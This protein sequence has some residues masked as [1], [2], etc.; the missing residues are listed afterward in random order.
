MTIIEQKA[1]PTIK[2]IRLSETHLRL[3]MQ[4]CARRRLSFSDFARMSLLGN[5][6]RDTKR[7]AVALWGIADW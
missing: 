4:E 2:S 5:L 7:R 3:I 6:S 1:A